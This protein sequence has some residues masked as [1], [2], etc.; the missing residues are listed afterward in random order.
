[1]YKGHDTY[2]FSQLVSLLLFYTFN[3]RVAPEESTYYCYCH[4]QHSLFGWDLA[5]HIPTTKTSTQEV[6]GYRFHLHFQIVNRLFMSY[7]ETK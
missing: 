5:F 7:C 1:M 6:A 2:F 4:C 3:E